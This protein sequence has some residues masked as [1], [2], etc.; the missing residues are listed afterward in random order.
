M[1][2]VNTNINFKSHLYIISA[3]L[4]LATI[5]VLIKL[6]DGN[7]PTLTLAFFK[8][9]IGFF[10]L[11][12]ITP[13]FD[14]GFIKPL[15]FRWKSFA[16][17]GLV[18]AIAIAMYTGSNTHTTIQNAV[19]LHYLYPFFVLFFAYYL[20]KERITK[21]KIITLIIALIG[22]FILNPLAIGDNLY[23]NML[24]L[25]GAVFYA[26]LITEM[27]AFDKEHCPSAIVWF[28]GFAS[29]FLLP[30]LFIYGVGNLIS[31][32]HYVLILGVVASGLAYFLYNL[33]LEEMEA[34][35]ASII[36]MIITPIVSITLA[37]LVVS[38]HIEISTIIGGLFLIIA[39]VYL[40]THSKK[41]KNS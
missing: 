5:G 4:C 10:F 36:A 38:E 25:I 2:N 20:L 30:S 31:V 21:T 6:I 28:L 1:I 29:L 3:A 35:N 9:F 37:F 13:F 26:V 11:I 27:R 15:K 23:G 14:N 18:Y 33:A 19:L 24:G 41:I 34:E 12:I 40:E 7:V 17:I 39:G 8:V 32:I 16:L 22:L